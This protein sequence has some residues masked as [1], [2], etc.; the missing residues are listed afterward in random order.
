M[1]IQIKVIEQYF[2]VHH[3]VQGNSNFSASVDEMLKCHH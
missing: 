3:A 1:T 2:P